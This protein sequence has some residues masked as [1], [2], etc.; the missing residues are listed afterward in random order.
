MFCPAALCA[1][2]SSASWLTVAAPPFCR[3][4]NDYCWIILSPSLPLPTSPIS[5]HVSLVRNVAPPCCEWN[6]FLPGTLQNSYIKGSALTLPNP[7][8]ILRTLTEPSTPTAFVCLSTVTAPNQ[9]PAP[10][11]KPYLDALLHWTHAE[12]SSLTPLILH[13]HR[14]TIFESPMQTL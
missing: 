3:S 7:S 12:L 14:P 6:L 13:S 1:S 8:P 4:V 11:S 5:Q 2:A 9:P 10:M